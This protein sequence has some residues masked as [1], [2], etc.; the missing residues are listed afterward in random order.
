MSLKDGLLWVLEGFESG[1]M[2]M[3]WAF[4]L[5]FYV[6]TVPL[7][8]LATILATFPKKLGHFVKSLATLAPS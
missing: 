8:S 2:L 4:K 6:D 7:F 3:F 1:S 5:S